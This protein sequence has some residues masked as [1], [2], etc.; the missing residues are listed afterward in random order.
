[1][2]AP[3]SAPKSVGGGAY[4]QDRGMVTEGVV[5]VTVLRVAAQ[6][7]LNLPGKEQR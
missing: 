1:M 7:V 2:L 6:P 3:Q 5:T 4:L